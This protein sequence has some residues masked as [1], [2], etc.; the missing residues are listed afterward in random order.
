MSLPLGIIWDSGNGAVRFTV[1]TGQEASPDRSSLFDGS[2]RACRGGGGARRALAS[3]G[4]GP[5]R[6]QRQHGDQ[7]AEAGE[8]PAASRLA[9]SAVTSR[10]RSRARIA[11][12]WSGAAG[13]GTSPC[14][15]SWLSSTSAASRSTTARSGSSSTPRSSVIKKDADCGRTGPPDVARRR[16][17]WAA[18]QRLVDRPPRLHRRDLDKDQHGS[19]P[20]LVAARRAPARQGA[21]RPLEDDDVPRRLAARPGRGAMPSRA[22]QRQDVPPLRR[23]GPRPDPAA[24][25]HRRHGQYRLDKSKGR[26]ARHQGGRRP[27]AFPAQI[28]ARPEPIEQL[29]S[30]LK[31]WLRR[32]AGRTADAVCNALGPILETVTPHE[33]SNYFTHAGYGQT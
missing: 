18:R 27:P 31:H 16:A 24:R 10:R 6:R 3:A 33:C 17:Q 7:L 12:G 29:F 26:A 2:S 19:A 8:P 32:D 14:A 21:A 20:G 4:G 23:Q 15:G 11:T 25:R 22:D 13:S 9:R 5:F 30:K 28:L 1:W